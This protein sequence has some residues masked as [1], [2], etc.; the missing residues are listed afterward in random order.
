[1]SGGHYEYAYSKIEQ[2]ADF[3][4]NDFVNDGKCMVEDWSAPYTEGKRKP[5]IEYDRLDDA[6]DEQKVIILKGIKDLIKDMR[7]NAKMAKELEWY[8]SGDTG[9]NTYLE[10]LSKIQNNG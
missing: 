6:T 3:I 1:M 4:E 5:E 7:L 9:A 10:R 8:L 2:L